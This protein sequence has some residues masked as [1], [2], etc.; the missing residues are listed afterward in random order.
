[1]NKK[2]LSQHL[3]DLYKDTRYIGKLEKFNIKKELF[4][5]LCGDNIVLYMLVKKGKIVDVSFESDGCMI[6]KVGAL[7]SLDMIKGENIEFLKTIEFNDILDS[8][9]IKEM[10][11]SRKKCAFL[12]FEGLKSINFKHL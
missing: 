10:T 6:S 2:F 12:A 8:I 11:E 1:M 3:L 9:G 7:V 5:P 4:N